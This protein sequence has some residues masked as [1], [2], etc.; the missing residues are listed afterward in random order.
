MGDEV[1][2]SSP[3]ME[4]GMKVPTP[5]PYKFKPSLL[6]RIFMEGGA[7]KEMQT[8]VQGGANQVSAAAGMVINNAA[9]YLD[10][11]TVYANGLLSKAYFWLFVLML[12]LYLACKIIGSS[13]LKSVF[14]KDEDPNSDF[15]N[16]E[17]VFKSRY[18]MIVKFTLVFILFVVLMHMF[19]YMVIYIFLAIFVGAMSKNINTVGKDIKDAFLKRFWL[20]EGGNM[21]VYI[22]FLAFALFGLFAFQ[23][24]YF[25]VARSFYSYMAYPDYIDREKSTAEEHSTPSKYIM[26]YSVIVFSTVLF[27]LGLFA[28]HFYTKPMA[29]MPLIFSLLLLFLYSVLFNIWIGFELEKKYPLVVVMLLVSLVF[30]I[31]LQLI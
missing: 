15:D 6:T 18:A 4:G 20:F 19:I 17:V 21:S 29:V 7:A 3:N 23:I 9:E 2:V 5:D 26:N 8:K 14:F 31:V 16:Q 1:T 28:L 30:T 25:A 13:S 22:Y 10:I 12:S 11:N 24:I 27:L